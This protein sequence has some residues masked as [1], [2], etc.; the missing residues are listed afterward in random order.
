[1]R[2]EL[3]KEQQNISKKNGIFHGYDVAKA[4]PV[5]QRLPRRSELN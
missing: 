4:P 3:C 1:M 5:F 2:F